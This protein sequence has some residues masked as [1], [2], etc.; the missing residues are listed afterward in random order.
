MITELPIA[1][2]PGRI[3]TIINE[4]D[5]DKAVDYLLSCDILGVDTETRPM[6][7]KGEQHKVALLQ[8]ASRDT[9][10]LFR[11]NDIGIPPS[12]IRLLEDCTVPKI[13]LS[14]H[15][16]LLSLHRRVE[17]NP[18]YFVDLQDIVKEIGIK[19]LSLQKLYA[20]IFHQKISKR[21]RLTNWEAEVLSDKQKLYAA[22][23][24]WA[25][26]KLYEEINRLYKTKEYT[27]VVSSEP[28][29]SEVSHNEEVVEIHR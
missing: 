28:M 8:V 24:A 10:F 13:G 27:L 21:Q 1:L 23:D 3:I 25:C 16:D 14:W 6:F 18:G 2:F 17:F 20:N 11:L 9:C 12:V 29:D 4:N 7:R 19:D 5:A 22:T 15:D 26:I